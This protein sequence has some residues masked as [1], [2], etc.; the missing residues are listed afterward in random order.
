[1]Q[2]GWLTRREVNGGVARVQG[3]YSIVS[4]TAVYYNLSVSTGAA[5]ARARR[6]FFGTLWRALRQ[7][8]HEV[9]GAIFAVIALSAVTS[10]IRSWGTA[11]PRWLLGLPV[12][13][14]LLMTYFS[15]TSFRW[16]RRVQ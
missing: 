15:I 8:F 14:A 13:Y 7:L 6:G 11:S 4:C 1:M 12:A 5:N 3:S 10:V 9:T 16:A 2:R